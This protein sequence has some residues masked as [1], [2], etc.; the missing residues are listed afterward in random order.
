MLPWV[1]ERL[2]RLDAE[3]PMLFDEDDGI[4]FEAVA[5]TD[6]DVILAAY[7]GITRSD[8]ETLSRIASV[9]AH[10]EA[11]WTATWRKMI[12][13]NAAGIGTAKAGEE[14]VRRL[15]KRIEEAV[16]KHPDLA[17]KTGMFVTHL[18]PCDLS[19][20]HFYAEADQRVQFLRD[21][22]MEIPQAVRTASEA[23]QYA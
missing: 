10:P 13:Q 2:D 3:P 4:D 14:L 12:R 7:S 9:I 19:T 21:L 16:A 18:D 22:G 5:A 15:E 1:T 11:P 17:S 20:I 23:D 6:P 8:Y